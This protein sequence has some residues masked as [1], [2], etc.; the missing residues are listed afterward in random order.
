MINGYGFLILLTIF[1]AVGTT[2]T[3]IGGR[4]LLPPKSRTV[5]ADEKRTGISFG[6]SFLF[7][8]IIMALFIII[9]VIIGIVTAG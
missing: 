8:L 6:D 7:F 3:Y 1:L 5:K 2:A 9:K 4:I